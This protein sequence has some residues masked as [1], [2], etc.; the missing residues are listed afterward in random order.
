MNTLSNRNYIKNQLPTHKFYSWY[1]IFVKRVECMNIFNL[2]AKNSL[3][4]IE[5][6][7]R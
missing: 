7:E 6:L 5:H 3:K 2:T 1:L 4:I